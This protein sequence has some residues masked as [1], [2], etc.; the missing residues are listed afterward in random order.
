[1]FLR[2]SHQGLFKNIYFYGFSITLKKVIP[3]KR[4]WQTKSAQPEPKMSQKFIFA[5]SPTPGTTPQVSLH[6]RK[7]FREVPRGIPRAM[8][9]RSDR[10][11]DGGGLKTGLPKVDIFDFF[12]KMLWNP[13]TWQK[14]VSYQLD[15]YV[16]EPAYRFYKMCDSIDI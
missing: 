7:C 5:A 13:R 4:F 1:M 2:S 14:S 8:Q 11:T 16:C 9:G 6:R 10:S 12:F 3:E 15:F